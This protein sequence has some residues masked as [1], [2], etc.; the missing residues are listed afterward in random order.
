M[1]VESFLEFYTSNPIEF[2][3]WLL[4]SL[5][6]GLG[7]FVVTIIVKR[8]HKEVEFNSVKEVVI[9]GA[10]ISI[11][12][13]VLHQLNQS[14]SDTNSTVGAD[15]ILEWE[16]ERKLLVSELS[17]DSTDIDKL[18]ASEAL[19]VGK[20]EKTEKILKR[21]YQ[22]HLTERRKSSDK[23]AEDAF[24]LARLMR[25]KLKFDEEIIYYERAIDLLPN[26]DA[27]HSNLGEVYFRLG[28][29]NE[30][31]KSFKK[32]LFIGELQNDED[33]EQ[34][35]KYHGNLG[36][37]YRLIG[38]LD[39]AQQHLEKAYE[40]DILSL[41][42][43]NESVV[44][45]LNNL[46]TNLN[47][48]GRHKE[49]L[50]KFNKALSVNDNF[51][52]KNHI[53]YGDL[54]SNIGLSYF[55]LGNYS[56]SVKYSRKAVDLMLG[57]VGLKHEN[58][59]TYLS[60]LANAYMKLSEY[61]NAVTYFEQAL[62]SGTSLFG[63][64]SLSIL[65]TKV[66]I[67]ACYL[68]MDNNDLALK[69]YSEAEL[70]VN[71]NSQESV[72][73]QMNVYNGLSECFRKQGLYERA[74]KYGEKALSFISESNN[75]KTCIQLLNNQADNLREASKFKKAKKLNEKALSLA[76]EQFGF[77]S[78]EA[79]YTRSKYSATL[80][81]SG[82]SELALQQ[83]KEAMELTSGLHDS[84]T[85]DYGVIANNYAA[86]LIATGKLNKAQ[87]LLSSIVRELTE[88]LGNEHQL[89]RKICEKLAVGT[90]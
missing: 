60:N 71:Q 75:P 3:M 90:N 20:L 32:A 11:P 47:E 22:K 64:N 83:S 17:E 52:A 42:D 35:A 53:S 66:S 88:K 4:G 73:Y 5:F 82:N 28:K 29:Y 63:S 54:W 48:L 34:L 81:E 23:A 58:S 78:F 84:V 79:A 56:E 69:H 30:A 70:I 1:T 2:W 65:P 68:S 13:E 24:D 33:Y 61:E 76:I 43:E 87:D 36:C 16:N 41:G 21:S 57:S 67:G 50:D 80:L 7:I 55:L 10:K 77:A 51:Q 37:T 14:Q 9:H 27:L 38:E 62:K 18:R 45:D 12:T 59:M 44:T 19:A 89:V 25:L 46:G 6:S 74:V 26:Q 31:V 39:K 72:Q 85:L 8:R 40:L 86:C 49:A 15:E